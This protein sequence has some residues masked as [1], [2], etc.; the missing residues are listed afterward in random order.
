MTDSHKPTNDFDPPDGVPVTSDDPREFLAPTP[1]I[2]SDDP[3]IRAF[4]E[5]AIEGAE[6]DIEKAVKL[7]YAVRDGIKYNPY[8]GSKHKKHYRASWT[9]SVGSGWCVQKGIVMA[10]VARAAGVPARLGYADVRNHLASERLL[11]VMGTDIFAFHG[12]VELW[13]EGQ[14]V[15][16][17]P[18]FNKELCEKF[19][20]MPQE[21]DGLSETLFQEHDQRGQRHME[22]LR[23]RGAYTDLPFREMLDDLSVRYNSQFFDSIEKTGGDFHAEAE[24]QGRSS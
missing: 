7:F 5:A 3:E 13:V 22:Y 18:V 14:W 24:A 20:V 8:Q 23:D 9:L 16:V 2:N 1:Y 21:F 12:W 4:A 19:H 15:K 17:T 11:E 10:A 6:T